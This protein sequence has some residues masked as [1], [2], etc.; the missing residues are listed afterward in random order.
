M[1][2]FIAICVIRLLHEVQ[3]CQ[4]KQSLA[5]FD[6]K[7]EVGNFVYRQFPDVPLYDTHS[8]KFRQF[9]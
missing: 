4:V 7:S 6:V 1:L 5:R 3:I 9:F 8:A 2:T